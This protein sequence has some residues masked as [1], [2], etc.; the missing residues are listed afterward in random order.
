M[1]VLA[2]ALMPNHWHLVLWPAEDRD[3]A[4][5][6]GWLSLT[7]ACRWQ[8]VHGA[9][10]LGH[11]YQGR[12]KAIPVEPG[13]HL[14]TVFRYVERNPVGARLVAR[15]EDWPYSSASDIG[16]PDRPTVHRWPVTRPQVAGYFPINPSAT[17][18]S[19][20]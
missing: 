9:R 3:L 13:E 10:G 11:V 18:R 20:P 2:Y 4:R 16:I 17:S 5:Y 12:Y 14:L 1:R 19:R 8:R 7:H 15:A 6:V